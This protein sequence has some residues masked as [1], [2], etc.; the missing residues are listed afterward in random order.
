MQPYYDRYGTLPLAWTIAG[1]P[2]WPGALTNM[3]VH[4]GPLHAA[5]NCF[6]ILAFG[7]QYGWRVVPLYLWGGFAASAAYVLASPHSQM[8]AVG[9]SA[10]LSALVGGLVSSRRLPPAALGWGRWQVPGALLMGCFMAVLFTQCLQQSWDV[11]GLH[12][13]GMIAGLAA[14]LALRED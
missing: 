8:P 2:L 12:L 13:A 7:R 1:R 3:F 9:A 6:W 11:L 10:A 4:T 5:A 14:G